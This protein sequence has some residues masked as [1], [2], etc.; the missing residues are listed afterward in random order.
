[1]LMLTN[2]RPKPEPFEDRERRSFA[3]SVLDNPEQLMMYAQSTG[4]VRFL[5]NY[6]QTNRESTTLL[7]FKFANETCSLLQ[8]I[9]GQRRRFM[10]ILCGFGTFSEATTQKTTSR[11]R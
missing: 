5:A 4:D 2:A 11:R 3:L 10:A 8:S 1:M 6:V 7:I 9:P